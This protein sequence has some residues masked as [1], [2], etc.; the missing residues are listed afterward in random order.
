MRPWLSPN[1]SFRTLTTG[2]RQ[3][4]VH[5]AAE[6]ISS[7]PSSTSSFTPKTTV[8][9]LPLP[10]A[11]TSTFLAPASMCFLAPSS[12]VKKP[13]FKDDIDVKVAPWKLCRI[14]LV[15]GFHFPA[16]DLEAALDLFE[17]TFETSLR[18]I[19]FHEMGEVI[20]ISQVIDCYHFEVLVILNHPCCKSSDTSKSINCYSYLNIWPP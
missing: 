17:F 18:S 19:I 2:A 6:T 11:E 9:I 13:V 1:L 3:F 15:E 4:V 20:V 8:F 14:F 12:S 5:E 7:E 10:G 16:V